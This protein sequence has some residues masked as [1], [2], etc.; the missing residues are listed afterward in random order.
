MSL[1]RVKFSIGPASLGAV[2]RVRDTRRHQPVTMI[3]EG[4]ATGF[5][6][7]FFGMRRE[8]DIFST[9]I[10]VSYAIWSLLVFFFISTP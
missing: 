2:V 9:W 7:Q 5:S 3:E 1:F 4:A 6:R 10:I 8:G